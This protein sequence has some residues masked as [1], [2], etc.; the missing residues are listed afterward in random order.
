MAASSHTEDGGAV[1]SKDGE[2]VILAVIRLGAVEG[3]SEV[4][5]QRSQGNARRGTALKLHLAN[6]AAYLVDRS[7]WVKRRS[8]TSKSLG[9][10]IDTEIKFAKKVKHDQSQPLTGAA[11]GAAA[12]LVGRFVQAQA[13]YWRFSVQDAGTIVTLV[14]KTLPLVGGVQRIGSVSEGAP[15]DD[16]PLAVLAHLEK[17]GGRADSVSEREGDGGS[18]DGPNGED[19]GKVARAAVGTGLEIEGTGT[20]TGVVIDD[21]TGNETGAGS[22]ERMGTG[23]MSGTGGASGRSA[24]SAQMETAVFPGAAMKQSFRDSGRRH[25]E[26][27]KQKHIETLSRLH[28]KHPDMPGIAEKL[29]KLLQWDCCSCVCVFVCLCVYVLVCLC[30]FVCVRVVL[31]FFCAFV[32]SY[33][34]VR[35]CVLHFCVCSYVESS[36]VFVFGE[37]CL[38]VVWRSLSRSGVPYCMCACLIFV[39]SHLSFR[40]DVVGSCADVGGV[41]VLERVEAERSCNGD[42]HVFN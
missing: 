3:W 17:G 6:V 9:R 42:S 13:G 30:V 2:G 1:L 25:D 20:V 23:T 34:V 12:A 37:Y 31:L 35:F 29:R 7:H 14:S 26:E 10:L 24:R 19:G 36:C 41:F 27:M 40:Y 21:E 33:C 4:V 18:G 39:C 11:G 38:F 15:P 8:C 32:Q 16:A 5:F 22:K 28:E